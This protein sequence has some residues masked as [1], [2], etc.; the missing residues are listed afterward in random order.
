MRLQV[1]NPGILSKMLHSFGIDME[2]N[3]RSYNPV[4]VG[5][6]RAFS[7]L[8]FFFIFAFGLLG[9]RGPAEHREKADDVAYEFIEQ[10][11]KAAL[12]ESEEFT[13]DRP[14]DLLRRRLLVGQALAVTDESSLGSDKLKRIEHWPDPNYL[15]PTY[16]G[17]TVIHV[18]ISRDAKVILS[19]VEALQVGAWNSFSYQSQKE[20]IFRAALELDLEA[21]QFRNIFNQEFTSLILSDTRGNDGFSGAQLSSDT[22]VSRKLASGTILAADL[23][24]DLA[25][26]LT[27]PKASAM[28]TK[29]DTSISIPLLR[30]SGKHIV[31]E[32]L[33]QAKRNVVYS[34]YKFER[35]KRTFAVNITS[36]Y[37]NVLRNLDTIK[38]S[39]ENYRGLVVS[40]RRSRRL[41]DFGELEEIQVDQAVQNE[42]RARNRWIEAIQRH[43]QSLDEFKLLLGLPTDA[44]IQLDR[45]EL[46]KLAKLEEQLT[47]AVEEDSDTTV[48]A[49]SADAPIV[50]VEP[51]NKNPGPLEMDQREAIELA[52]DNRLDLRTA[53]GRVYDAQ[54]DVVVAADDLRAELTFFGSASSGANRSINSADN[55]DAK[56]RADKAAFSALLTMDLPIERT[57]ERDEYRNSLINLERTLRDKNRRED[58][59]KLDIRN[60]LRNLLSTR[61]SLQIQARSVDVA[62]KRVDST[63]LF[64][65]AGRAAIRDV[66]EAQESLLSAQ[67]ALTSALVAYRISELQLQS[68]MGL[69]KV[70]SD[71]LWQEYVPQTEQK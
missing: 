46:E 20:D 67:N 33:T 29:L 63:A 10:G 68:D 1:T 43:A 64:L 11:Q 48:T 55:P 61:E 25:N 57:K 14:S 6:F 38:N 30:G 24:I 42:L 44:K 49:S 53:I 60:D 15:D 65:E 3:F 56:L 18:K 17:P 12:G 59:V 34:I 28:G 71:G 37:L 45:D 35:F 66:L 50:L 36:K 9:C 27:S 8:I 31:T 26:L 52:L 22:G 41:A 23:A 39:E 40:V 32:R 21:N 4:F 62:Q 7:A 69:L 5:R 70:G 2:H 47:G 19:L 51:G 58:E 13:I 54:R 16:N